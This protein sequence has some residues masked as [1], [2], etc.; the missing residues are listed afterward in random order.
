MAN[1]VECRK[2]KAR[3]FPVEQ[4]CVRPH[5]GA[6]TRCSVACPAHAIS[7]EDDGAA[8][9]IDE[10]A[11]TKCGICMGVCDGFASTRMSVPNLHAHIRK[12]ALRGEMVYLTCKENVFPG[13][14]PAPNVVVLP[15][16]ACISP[17][18]WTLMLTENLPLV[19]SCDFKYCSDCDRAPGRGEMLFSRSIEMAEEWTG[20]TV[21]FDREIPEAESADD[22]PEYGR[23][24]A[25][26]SVKGDVVDVLNG[27]RMLKN[28][29]TLQNY[30]EKK[31]RERAIKKLNLEPTGEF[32]NSFAEGGT[33]ATLFTPRRKLL[34]EAI[35][36]SPHIAQ[37]IPVLL[38]DTNL[39][40]CDDCLACTK[41][42]L[43]GARNI[44]REDGSLTFNE[45]LCIGCGACVQA[46]PKNACELIETTAD[47]FS[48]E[49]EPN[50]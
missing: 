2:P 25:I 49:S 24:E 23:R 19:V 8:P 37:R 48:I 22:N 3:F 40:L 31:E 15:C 13:F 18:L 27:K 50:H 7:F 14:I 35:S 17:E 41:V 28:S 21:R 26:D 10:D 34:L 9:S 38:S 45:M 42:C 11:C 20:G 4:F 39:E 29:D 46:C 30:Y 6:C 44:S 16:L 36:R 12:I 32:L 1:E 33:S 47:I 43:T 5:G